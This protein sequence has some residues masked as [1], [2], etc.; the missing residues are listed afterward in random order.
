MKPILNPVDGDI[1]YQQ[2]HTFS[3]PALF[4]GKVKRQ[5]R[6]WYVY[7]NSSVT[8]LQTFWFKVQSTLDIYLLFWVISDLQ[9]KDSEQYVHKQS[10]LH[11]IYI[12]YAG[13]SLTYNTMTEWAVCTQTA[14]AF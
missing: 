6:M 1:T 13:S 12:C 9:Y 4:H 11:W 2:L 8:V 5:L 7:W 14:T 10:S 3:N